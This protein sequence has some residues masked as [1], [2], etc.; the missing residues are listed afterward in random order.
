MIVCC[1]LNWCIANVLHFHLLCFS[2]FDLLHFQFVIFNKANFQLLHFQ[3][4]TFL[5]ANFQVLYFQCVAFAICC[6][7]KLLH[8]Q[9]VA[10]SICGSRMCWS[11]NAMW[12]RKLCG[13]YVMLIISIAQLVFCDDSFVWCCIFLIVNFEAILLCGVAFVWLSILW[14]DIGANIMLVDNI[15]YVT[16]FIWHSV[17][18]YLCG[19]A[20]VSSWILR[21]HSD[22]HI[23]L[24]DNIY[25]VTCFILHIL[26]WFTCVVLHLFDR[27][28]CDFTLMQTSCWLTIFIMSHVLFDI[29]CDAL[30][31]WC[32]ICVVVHFVISHW[33]KYRFVYSIAPRIPPSQNFEL[34]AVNYGLLAPG[35]AQIPVYML[36]ITAWMAQVD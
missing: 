36:Q 32:C 28:F 3:F 34:G 16:C 4:V 14:F 31:M 17:M 25:Y 29:F 23:M 21:V 2:M 27:D 11:L 8:F 9:F 15:Y 26:W 13:N 19:D 5:T 24:I 35:V 12:L 22:A 6:I 7:L 10:C 18:I 20:F 30:F 1:M 33:C